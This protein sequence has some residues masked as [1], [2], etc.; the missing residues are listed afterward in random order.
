MQWVFY[1]CTID[2]R[3]KVLYNSGVS[4]FS[5]LL[6]ILSPFHEKASLMSKGRMGW[7]AKIKAANLGA[8]SVWFHCA[9]LG[10]FE[11]GRP[12]METIKTNYP[13]TSM[14]VTFFSSSG[15]EVRKNY[16]HADL[17]LYLP[18]DSPGNAEKFIGLIDPRMAIFIKYEF[19]HNYLQELKKG[20]IPVFLVSGIF[21]DDQKFFRKGWNFFRNMLT[22]FTHFFV[23]NEQSQFLLHSINFHNVTVAGDTRFDRVMEICSRPKQIEL[24]ELFANNSTVMVIGSSWPEDMEVLLPLINDETHRL[25]FIIAPHEI[26]KSKIQ[27]LTQCLKCKFQ[28]FSEAEPE[29][30]GESRV[31]I[32]DNIGLLSSLY[33]YG[34]LAYIGGAFG[35]GLHNILEAATFGMP[36]IFGKGKDNDKYQEAT[37]LVAQGGAFEV[38]QSEDLIKL[39]EALISDKKI[40]A[41]ASN[42]SSG[43]VRN[44]AGAT[45]TVMKHLETY[46]K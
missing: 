20:A 45:A 17:I 9:S 42:I 46:L 3:M 25:K 39:V 26:E 13:E 10:E 14:I 8:G 6:R 23:Q 44:H 22:C 27:K 43:Y 4:L 18:F 30:M 16:E 41:Q 38:S 28:L 33:Q 40:L 21:R 19:W 1:F 37:D 35:D 29:H 24:A 34:D 11:Q 5:I 12:I 15:Y 2:V 36:I 32:I 7:E 31:L